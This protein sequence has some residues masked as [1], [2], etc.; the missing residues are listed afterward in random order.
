MPL[1]FLFTMQLIIYMSLLGIAFLLLY[2]GYYTMQFKNNPSI[3][4]KI[5]A[6]GIFF[7]INISPLFGGG[8]SY[9]AGNF[10]EDDVNTTRMTR[11]AV[12]STYDNF[13]YFFFMVI[14]GGYGAVLFVMEEYQNW[15]IRFD[16][17]ERKL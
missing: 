14:L 1:S 9:Q 6:Y 17:L 3:V 16:D 8:L 13:W 4:F 15:K 12:Y 10:I 11:T 7:M 2:L 5:I